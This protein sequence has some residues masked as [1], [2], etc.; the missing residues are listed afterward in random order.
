MSASRIHPLWP[1]GRGP[2]AVKANRSGGMRVQSC[3]VGCP[4]R[5]CRP[6]HL[7]PKP[8]PDPSGRHQESAIALGALAAYLLEKGHEVH[9]VD[10]ALLRKSFDE[11]ARIVADYEPD[12]VGIGGIITAYSYIIELSHAL[13][14]A[15]PRVPIVLGGQVSVNNTK[16]CFEHMAIDHVIHGYGQ[17][18]LEKLLRHVRGEL[19][20]GAIPGLSYRKGDLIVTNPGREFFKNLDDMPFPAYHLFDMEHYAEPGRRQGRQIEILREVNGKKIKVKVNDRSLMVNGNLGCTDRCSFCIHEQEFVGLKYHSVEY[21]QKLIALLSDQYGIN[22]FQMGEEMFIAIPKR[23]IEFSNMMMER[24]PD[25]YW[26]ASARADFVTEEAVAELKRG[27]C[28]GITWGFESGSQKMLDLMN[29]RMT[30]ETNLAALKRTHDA[31]L[32][33]GASTYSLS[34]VTGHVGETNETVKDTM[35]NIYRGNLQR[36]VVFFATPYPGGRLW[37]WAVERGIVKDSHEF[38][39]RISDRDAGN[40]TVN[41]TPYPDFIVKRWPRMIEAAFQKNQGWI[42]VPL[43]HADSR[44]P[45]RRLLS[46]G[47]RAYFF[48]LWNGK[49]VFLWGVLPRLFDIYSLYYKVTRRFYKTVKDRTYEYKVDAKG[50]LLPDRLIVAKPQRYLTP[51]RLAEVLLQP[52]EEIRLKA[53]E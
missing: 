53:A 43:S 51:E 47:I 10:A 38:L 25:K 8:P 23:T 42:P 34:F 31:G 19:D 32:I 35:Q 44:N 4:R 2:A 30:V 12:L 46:H 3:G 40:F 21:L 11:L 52:K 49:S 20:A 36:G 39:R 16:N 27:T 14:K 22:M 1:A 18:A 26:I 9:V 37:D 33:E 29:K 5:A 13:K 50:A 41:L 7:K 45:F 24:F 15:L 28:I 6:T 48:L 17:I